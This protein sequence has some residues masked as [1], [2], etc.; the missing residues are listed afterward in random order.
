MNFSMFLSIIPQSVILIF[1]ST[2]LG[3]IVGQFRK[4]SNHPSSFTLMKF[5]SAFMSDWIMS[6]ATVLLIHSTL[7]IENNE[8]LIS[9]SIFFGFQGFKKSTDSIKKIISNKF[10]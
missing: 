3:A 5:F 1:P 7:H 10:K 2:F 6:F 9:M 4:K 8:A